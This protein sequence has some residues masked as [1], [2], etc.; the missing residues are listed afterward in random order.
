MSKFK[1][2]VI[3]CVTLAIS[4]CLAHHEG[5]TDGFIIVIFEK[6]F[7]GTVNLTINLERLV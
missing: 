6:L 1:N 3:L 7:I 2:D 5:L 4:W